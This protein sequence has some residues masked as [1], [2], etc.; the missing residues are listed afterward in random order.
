MEGVGVGSTREMGWEALGRWVGCT[1]EMEWG[2]LGR[3]GG[4]HQGELEGE[5]DWWM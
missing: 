4:E 1:R 2:A 3:W 5:K